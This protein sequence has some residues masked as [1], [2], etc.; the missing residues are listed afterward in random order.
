M[1]IC[2][3]KVFLLLVTSQHIVMSQIC[4]ICQICNSKQFI[5][6]NNCSTCRDNFVNNFVIWFRQFCANNVNQIKIITPINL[7]D[8]EQCND[9]PHRHFANYEPNGIKTPYLDMTE[10]IGIA[11][12]AAFN[13]NIDLTLGVTIRVQ[14]E[15]TDTTVSK[16]HQ[17]QFS[18]SLPET[19]ENKH[20]IDFMNWYCHVAMRAFFGENEFKC[21]VMKHMFGIH[22]PDDDSD[23][24]SDDDVS[25]ND[26]MDDGNDDDNDDNDDNDDDSDN[27][28]MDDD[29]DSDSD[30]DV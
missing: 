7:F 25:D 17:V 5:N 10:P 20:I 24:D 30:D 29:S 26:E 23:D 11:T 8:D 28:E 1:F 3:Y 6:F 19:P 9:Y 22:N 15:C 4:Q 2:S 14:P 16:S 21:Q 27:D 12:F 13:Y 18:F